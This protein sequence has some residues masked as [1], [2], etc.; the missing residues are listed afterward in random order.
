MEHLPLPK[1]VELVG[2]QV[3]DAA[4]EVHRENGPGLFEGLYEACLMREFELRGL[5][6]QSQVPL[7][8]QYKGINVEV[9]YRLD[10]VVERKVILE[11]KTVEKLIPIH[12]AQLLTYL[13]VARC[14]LG[15]LLN[16]NELLMK[17]GIKR[18]VAGP[19]DQPP[20]L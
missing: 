4:I 5:F 2:K 12:H 16:F 10:I 13:K 1:D 18:K 17:D 19:F 20:T 11:L 7:P 8:V 15:Y 14:Q 3:V 9:G 6:A